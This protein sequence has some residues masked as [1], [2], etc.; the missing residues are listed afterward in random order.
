V[1]VYVSSVDARSQVVLSAYN[2]VGRDLATE[3]LRP[4][5]AI[6][7]YDWTDVCQ[8]A[9]VSTYPLLRVYRP[10]ADY[11]TYSGFLSKAAL[12]AAVKLYVYQSFWHLNYIWT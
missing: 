6:N 12:Y 3:G 4:L 8:L 7:C 9:N 11:V 2:D 10:H 1:C 5:A